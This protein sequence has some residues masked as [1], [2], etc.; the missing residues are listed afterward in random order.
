[1][2]DT[3]SKNLS[4]V[5]KRLGGR[6]VLDEATVKVALRDIRHALLEADVAL[7]VVRDLMEKVSK[8]STGREILKSVTPVQQIIKVVHDVMIDTL[9]AGG[10]APSELALT[11]TPPVVA[12]MVGLQGSGKTTT[13]AKI[14]WRFGVQGK[15]KVLM[16][17]LDVNRPAAMEQLRI[18]GENIGVDTLPVVEGQ[19]PVDIASRALTAG[20]L[21]GYDVILLD[22]A[23]RLHADEALMSEM[24]AIHK[25]GTPRETLLVADSLTGQ[26]AINLAEQ[27][28]SRIPL[29][30]IVLTRADGDARGGAALS[31]GHV[32]GVA[33]RYLGVGERPDALEI[34]DAER[35]ARRILGMGDVAGLVE[36]AE[37]TID[38]KK[39]ER[40]AAKMK[41][42]QFDLEDLAEQLE[43]MG[44]M[45]GL[46]SVLGMLL[47]ALGRQANNVNA[48]ALDDGLIKRQTAIIKS[49]T[50]KERTSPKLLNASRKRRVAAGA[51]VAVQEVNRVLKMHRQMADMTKKLGRKGGN[52]E[53]VAGAGANAGGIMPS[54]PSARGD[55]PLPSSLSGRLSSLSGLPTGKSTRKK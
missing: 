21:Q 50:P 14:A 55:S 8:Q 44:R 13:T 45:G 23:G 26:D 37:R 12:M 32:T 4:D 19:A 6:G 30:G 18:L 10:D 34:F 38:T 3:L 40:I 16:A 22:T 41:K 51:G 54:L 17:S 2:F 11:G 39:A 25:V 9:S 20:R 42:G 5:F 43:Q 52:L 53:A 46:K 35:M 33:V 31:M 24:A 15:S 48:A 49:M 28:H 1:M 47:P 7:P 27:F 29:T 36:Q